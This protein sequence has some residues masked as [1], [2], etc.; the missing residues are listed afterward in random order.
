M[1]LKMRKQDWKQQKTDGT[2]LKIK[3]IFYYKLFSFSTQHSIDSKLSR[4]L[5]SKNLIKSTW[6]SSVL[7]TLMNLS[8][9]WNDSNWI[10]CFLQNKL[11]LSKMTSVTNAFHHLFWC[12]SSRT[13]FLQAG[14][15][16]QII[17]PT[18]L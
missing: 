7:I 18:E 17:S 16:W 8:R 9:K 14:E 11:M 15:H 6:Y 2:E 13:K 4:P 12:W 3:V 5:K 10:H 1:D